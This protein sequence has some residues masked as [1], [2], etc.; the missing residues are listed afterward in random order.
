MFSVT[1]EK[2]P[3]NKSLKFMSNNLF[4][5]DAQARLKWSVFRTKTNPSEI[6]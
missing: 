3:F 5:G 2:I 6:Q 1:I 4:T